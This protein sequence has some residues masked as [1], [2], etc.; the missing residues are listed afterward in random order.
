MHEHPQVLIQQQNLKSAGFDLEV[1]KQAFYPTP[2]ISVE[3]AQSN[4]GNDP[5]YAGAPQ[6]ATLKVQQPLWT[7]G[8]LTAQ[9]NKATANQDIEFA[10]LLEI[11]QSLA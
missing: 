6:V 11:Q 2:S 3:R 7:G 5:S 10:K 9:K 1:S 8:R 4:G